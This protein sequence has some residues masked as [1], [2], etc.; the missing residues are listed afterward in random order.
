M[1]TILIHICIIGIIAWAIWTADQSAV[2]RWYW[3]TLLLKLTAGLLLGYIYTNHYPDSDTVYFFTEGKVWAEYARA[4]ALDYL[5][6]LWQDTEAPFSGENRTLFM[7]KAVSLLAWATQHNYWLIA[8]YFSLTAFVCAWSLV[9]VIARYF[10]SMTTAAVIGFLLF[11]SAVFWSSGITKES[12]AMAGICLMSVFF[13]RVWVHNRITVYNAVSVI[14]ALWVAWSLK[15]FYVAVFLPVAFTILI[16][17]WFIENRMRASARTAY[18]ESVLFLVLFLVMLFV[19]TFIH[20]N[21]SPQRIL[22]VIVESN[23]AFTEASGS[24]LCI[25]Y[26]DLEPTLGR[27]AAN[28]PWAVFSGLFRPFPWEAVNIFQVLASVE[29]AVILML[30]L[31]SIRQF[32]SFTESPDRLLV[33]GVLVYCFMLCAFLALSAP[34]F[35]TLVRYR[36]G[37]IPFLVMLLSYRSILSGLTGNL[38]KSA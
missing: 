26:S 20:P 30:F 36:V 29:N 38:F 37:F 7:V 15:Y 22:E 3:P 18:R 12:L 32:K 17:R 28:L 1:L 14:I 35:G 6:R 5:L 11:P 19:V 24:T 8:G 9:T 33:F 16:T 31:L 23:A 10:P 2:K 34:N 27:I 25:Q 21:F 4:D 13:I